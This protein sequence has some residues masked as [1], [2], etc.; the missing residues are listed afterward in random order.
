MDFEAYCPLRCDALC[1]LL[2]LLVIC[3]IF[4]LLDPGSGGSSSPPEYIIF[5][6]WTTGNMSRKTVSI[7]KMLH[8]LS[9]GQNTLAG[10]YR[11]E[12]VRTSSVHGKLTSCEQGVITAAASFKNMLYNIMFTA[13]AT[14][15]TH[16]FQH[17]LF[18]LQIAAECS[19][20]FIFLLNGVPYTSFQNVVKKNNVSSFLKLWRLNRSLDEINI[21][22]LLN[23]RSKNVF[24]LAIF[25]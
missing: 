19:D 15:V 21:L 12:H 20:S 3:L 4:L 22:G 5:F 10:N 7:F 1:I 13:V 8:S 18:Y 25:S 24:Y 23:S 6:Y 2:F 17:S 11:N 14:S 16:C 9:L